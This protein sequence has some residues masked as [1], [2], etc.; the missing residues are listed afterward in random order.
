MATIAAHG[1]VGDSTA[2]A[3]NSCKDGVAVFERVA[4]G[5][6]EKRTAEAPGVAEVEAG[7]I[8]GVETSVG[9]GVTEA[10]ERAGSD[11][12]SDLDRVDEGVNDEGSWISRTRLLF[13]SV[14]ATMGMGVGDRCTPN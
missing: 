2:V 9:A 4:R 8:E 7:T 10:L 3:A 5:D 14:C 11:G 13:C 6:D 12:E 1:A